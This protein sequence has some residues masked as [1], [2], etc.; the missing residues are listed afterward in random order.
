MHNFGKFKLNLS[1]ILGGL[2][3]GLLLAGIACGAAATATPP[4]TRAPQVTAAPV[5]TTAPAATVAAA[6]AAPAAPKATPVPAPPAA[7]A[8]T[9]HPGKVTFMVGG[10]EAGRMFPLHIVSHVHGMILHGFLVSSN[11][12]RELIPGIATQWKVSED[13][14]TW[15]VT[16][17]DGVKF[18][19]GRTL[20]AEDVYFTWLQGYGPGAAEK[21]TSSSNQAQAKNTLKIEQTDP[22]RVSITTKIVDSGFPYYISDI[23]GS[24][25][26]VVLPRW[27]LE[28][29]HDDEKL[30][31]YDRNPIAA[32][33]MKLVR[34]VP[35]EVMQFE[36]FDDYYDPDTR[37]R[38]RS[39][40]LR[41]VPEEATRIAALRAKEVDIAPVSLGARKQ[42]EAGGSRLVFS[43]EGSY[44]QGEL[45]CWKAEFA[46]S[47][48]KVRQALAYALDMN[49]F[50]DKLWGPEV[51]VP[52]GW[53]W[54][55]PATI[56][57]SPELDPV[58]DPQKARQLLA[59]AGYPGGKGFPTLVV[60]VWS[61]RAV[62][63]LPE[64][65]QLAADM[66]KKELG[67]PVEVKLGEEAALK[68]DRLG[69]LHGQVLWRDNETR[70]D[71][72]SSARTSFGTPG[73]AA[74]QT[75][76]PAIF[77]LVEETL[78]VVDPTKRHD[79]F[80]KLYRVLREEQY[81]LGPGYINLP[82]GVGPR[83]VEWTPFPMAFWPSGL[84]TIVLKP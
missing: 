41:L 1:R 56:G 82:W 76:D 3:V 75:D 31:A 67:I 32:G 12:K 77:K 72:S 66:W 23:T 69:G 52:K 4:P 16:I 78:A 7:K 47:K 39:M 24:V 13:G 2:A 21:S 18:H 83:I 74:A 57:Y 6:P 73:H 59:E 34:H 43:L 35:F 14:K 45:W 11:E 54:V 17:R 20:T 26:G 50:R 55:T 19:D 70:T 28:K 81:R 63:Y 49:L 33:I 40:D 80:N 84:H 64:S 79:A 62:P 38:F 60:N 22:K 44:L 27:E 51:F 42:V 15:T 58:F 9:V 5:S 61:S 25:Q 53:A 10:W 46:C 68:K 30:L 37:V 8:P 71:G 29:I 36:R 65:A 48:T